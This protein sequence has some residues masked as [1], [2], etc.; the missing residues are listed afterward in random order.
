MIFMHAPNSVMGGG[1]GLGTEAQLKEC[2]YPN[3]QTVYEAVGQYSFGNGGAM[4]HK[5]MLG[6]LFLFTAF[7]P[8]LV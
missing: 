2:G 1:W 4:V 6:Q 5:I 8:G 7:A 3:S